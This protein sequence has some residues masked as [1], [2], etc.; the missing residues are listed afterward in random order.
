[1]LKNFTSIGC[2]LFMGV[3]HGYYSWVLFMG[4]VFLRVVNEQHQHTRAHVL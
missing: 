1:M 3:V 4:V 2:C